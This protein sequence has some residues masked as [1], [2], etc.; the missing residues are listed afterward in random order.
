MKYEYFDRYEH[1]WPSPTLEDPFLISEDF[2]S[3]ILD[4][5]NERLKNT[6]IVIDFTD[7]SQTEY[8]EVSDQNFESLENDLDA[9]NTGVIFYGVCQSLYEELEHSNLKSKWTISQPGNSKL[10]VIG[11][12]CK[13]LNWCPDKFEKSK[14]TWYKSID[15]KI[16]D[17]WSEFG[18]ELEIRLPSTPLNAKGFYNAQEILADPSTFSRITI[19][20][21]RLYSNQQSRLE[22]IVENK[23]Y[24]EIKFLALSLR[25]SPF[26]GA[27]SALQHKGF[28]VIA[29]GINS[30]VI[31]EFVANPLSPRVAYVLVSDF[32]VGGTELRIAESFANHRQS[33]VASC[34]CLGKVLD[35]ESYSDFVMIESLTN[36]VNKGTKGRKFSL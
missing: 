7:K 1:F 20:L 35:S 36:I 23:G 14:T 12:F 33:I 8:F 28:T 34:L 4:L 6:I 30:K 18:D 27:L 31:N 24:D 21:S 26:V 10:R 22:D 9:T 5:P 13:Q 25:A 17:S 3:R 2:F 32:V 29:P 19:A 16:N 15:K 11:Y